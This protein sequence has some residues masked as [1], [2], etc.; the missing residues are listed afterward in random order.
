MSAAMKNTVDFIAHQL[1]AGRFNPHGRELVTLVGTGLELNNLHAAGAWVSGRLDASHPIEAHV[2]SALRDRFDDHLARTLD[3]FRN[4]DAVSLDRPN[5]LPQM[6]L[7]DSECSRIADAI[8]FLMSGCIQREHLDA[9][10]GMLLANNHPRSNVLVQWVR[11]Q[12]SCYAFY[13]AELTLPLAQ[14]LQR[15]LTDL[16][17]VWV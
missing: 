11:S 5:Y 4:G 14:R 2:L 6:P 10:V 13:P 17:G 8:G 9:A 12:K 3:S 16:G 7:T 15:A 1:L